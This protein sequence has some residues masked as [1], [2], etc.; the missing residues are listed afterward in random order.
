MKTKLKLGALLVQKQG[1]Q[2]VE[3]HCLRSVQILS[4]L[5]SLLFQLMGCRVFLHMGMEFSLDFCFLSFLLDFQRQKYKDEKS[6][7]EC[8]FAERRRNLGINS[9]Q[10]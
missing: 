4:G 1:E 7:G 9:F 10:I 6:C 3:I 2:M 5:L 8:G